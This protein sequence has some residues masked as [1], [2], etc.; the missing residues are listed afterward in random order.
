[1]P[2]NLE[3]WIRNDKR[4][5]IPE[6]ELAQG[7]RVD[8]WGTNFPQSWDLLTGRSGSPL[9]WVG[10]YTAKC[11]S[12]APAACSPLVAPNQISQPQAVNC[13]TSGGTKI[14]LVRDACCQRL[15]AVPE[16][17]GATACKCR[18][19]SHSCDTVGSAGLP[20]AGAPALVS[21]S[22]ETLGALR[23]MREVRASMVWAPEERQPAKTL[24]ITK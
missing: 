24:R 21:S 12:P 17:P 2:W 11:G 18:S 20:S 22:C 10:R 9:V 23:S 4:P 13:L 7:G 19:G 15:C 14:G 8:E 6:S 16:L 5:S 3:R 1:M